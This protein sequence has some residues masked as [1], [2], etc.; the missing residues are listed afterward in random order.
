MSLDKPH[1]LLC[2][3]FLHKFVIAKSFSL[4]SDGGSAGE[5]IH[6]LLR[7]KKE[8]LLL[9]SQDPAISRRLSLTSTTY[10]CHC[11]F[12]SVLILTYL[13]ICP[14]VLQASSVYLF[15]RLQQK[16][17]YNVHFRKVA[18]TNLVGFRPLYRPQRP[19]R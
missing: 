15:T 1:W 17:R 3:I 8:V 6:H 12:K 4:Q 2:A 11:L 9:Y 19:F 18:D 5:D 13:I 10:R 16:K 14:H 7:K